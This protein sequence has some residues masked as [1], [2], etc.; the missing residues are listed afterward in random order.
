MIKEEQKSERS[1][2][3]EK[4]RLLANDDLWIETQIE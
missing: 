2:S 1:D 3:L 4:L